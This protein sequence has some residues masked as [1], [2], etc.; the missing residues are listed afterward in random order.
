MGRWAGSEEG[1][2]LGEGGDEVGEAKD[3]EAVEGRGGVVDDDEA[4]AAFVGFAGEGG[5]GVDGEG[6]AEDEEEVGAAAGV[7]GGLEGVFGEAFAVEDDVG[8][9]DAAA[10]A[11]GD[12]ALADGGGD[13]VVGIGAAAGE[14]VVQVGG[15]VELVDGAAAGEGVEAVDVLGDDGV[16]EA[17]AFELG[18]GAVDDV[19]A[20]GVEGVDEVAAPFVE[21]R[22]RSP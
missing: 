12:V 3:G 22:R 13:V 1:G 11:A 19:G 15:A 10:G 2:E 21:V 5:G 16:E 9:E 6:G 20:V 14:A 4:G 7:E 17:A 18:E 8:L